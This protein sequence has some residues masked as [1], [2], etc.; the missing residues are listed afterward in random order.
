MDR[1]FGRD[2]ARGEYAARAMPFIDCKKRGNISKNQR[3]HTPR[4]RYN[5]YK[6]VNAASPNWLLLVEGGQ[7]EPRAR[8]AADK[9]GGVSCPEAGL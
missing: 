6:R 9:T 3:T 5:I 8:K 1:A 7:Y 2:K 4:K